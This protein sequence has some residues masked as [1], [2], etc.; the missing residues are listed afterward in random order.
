MSN[1]AT[2]LYGKL[3]ALPANGAQP[4][5]GLLANVVSGTTSPTP[6]TTHQYLVNTLET[7]AKALI[8][9]P[10]STVIDWA[11]GV[12]PKTKA[13]IDWSALLSSLLTDLPTILADLGPLLADFGVTI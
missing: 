3:A 6:S 8:G 1:F 10:A 9:V 13:A 11:S 7:H 12:H 4:V 2:V 5:N